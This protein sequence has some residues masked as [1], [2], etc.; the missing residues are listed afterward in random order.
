MRQALVLFAA[1]VVACGSGSANLPPPHLVRGAPAADLAAGQEEVTLEIVEL[2]CRPCAA[3]IVSGSRALPGVT[4]VS[5]EL[6]T[7][8]LTLRYDTAVIARERLVSSVERIVANIQ[9]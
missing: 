9:Q 7:K 4:S 3:Q 5:M 1:L 6:A 8:T 2:M